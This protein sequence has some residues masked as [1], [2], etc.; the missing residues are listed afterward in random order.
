LQIVIK[1]GVDK[2]VIV[3]ELLFSIRSLLITSSLIVSYS[4]LT[5]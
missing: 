5:V 1:K 4:I 3:T 2:C